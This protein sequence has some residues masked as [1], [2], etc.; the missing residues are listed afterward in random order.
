MT[1]TPWHTL[2]AD[3]LKTTTGTL[4]FKQPQLM[5]VINTTPD[6]FYE[7]SRVDTIQAAL[8]LAE[9]HCHAGADWLDIGGESSRPGSK[10]ISSQDTLER[11]IPI[12]Q[13]IRTHFN[14]HLSIDTYH[15]EVMQAAIDAGVDLIN[16]ITALHTPQAL[17][18]I[19]HTQTAVCLM[20]MNGTPE[21]MQDNPHYP[22]DNVIDAIKDFFTARLTRCAQQGIDLSRLIIDPGFGFGKTAE[23][24]WTLL[25]HLS[26]L[27]CF[28][29]PI[30]V[31]LSRK[32]CIADALGTQDT[33]DARGIGSTMAAGL[34]YL[35]GATFIRTHDVAWAQHALAIMQAYQ[36]QPECANG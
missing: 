26:E 18:Q 13:A 4:C 14:V 23:H 29:R 15:P 36:P 21:T 28:N 3:Q 1:A 35:N 7:N 20:H 11:V 34:A 6:S 10:R 12:I 31:G 24:N 33:D 16:D 17:T 2:H 32:R 5:G 9:K 19:E 8:A 30:L 22:Q 25:R 27:R